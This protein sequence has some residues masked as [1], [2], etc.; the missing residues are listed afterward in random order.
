[1]RA[2]LIV[3]G[4]LVALAGA[5]SADARGCPRT[6][7]AGPRL[8]APILLVTGCGAYRVDRDGRVSVAHA[9]DPVPRWAHG[10]LGHPDRQTWVAHA[11]R[12][13]QVYRAGRL[14]WQSHVTGGSDEV[15][16]G[17][18]RI[19]F[20]SYGRGE[21]PAVWLARLDGREHEVARGEAIVG[22]TR[23]GLVT[24]H[25]WDLRL[26]ARDGRLL[27]RIGTAR[28]AYR[29]PTRGD[30][31]LVTRD[32]RVV[33]TDGLR[34]RTIADLDTLGYARQS[35]LSLLPNGLLQV[36]SAN[37]VLFVGA[38]GERFASAALARPTKSRPGAM[39]V[40]DILRLPARDRL[41]FVVSRRAVRGPGTET[42]F[43]LDRGH[44]VPRPLFSA[45]GQWVT[46]GEWAT[47]S[48]RRRWILYASSEGT[49]AIVDPLHA[50]RAINLSGLVRRLS[51]R[52]PTPDDYLKASWLR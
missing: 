3:L 17:H 21:E 50:R 18:Q 23:A 5:P 29:D 34:D 6:T 11:N 31:V 15:A 33:R 20:T 46:C 45:R 19:V 12:L 51:P 28:G 2:R 8:P 24:Q 25:V 4:A 43:R 52:R 1:M 7:A 38:D 48:I 44:R 41:L 27:R 47:L 9:V 35:W 37:R 16:I 14:L 49:L 26:R 32:G 13:L 30:V 39:I 42:V 36:T 10:A 22:W 40:G